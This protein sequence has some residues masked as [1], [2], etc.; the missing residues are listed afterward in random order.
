LELDRLRDHA[1]WLR[2]QARL[3]M[4]RVINLERNGAEAWHVGEHRQRQE[5]LERMLAAAEARIKELE[6]VSP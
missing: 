5:R 3:Q 6:A 4:L 1:R 2:K